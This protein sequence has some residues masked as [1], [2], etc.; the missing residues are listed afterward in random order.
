MFGLGMGELLVILLIV[1][2]VFG[3]GKLPEIGSSLGQG[4]KSFKK[5]VQGEEEEKHKTPPDKKDDK[6]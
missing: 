2:V 4:I 3:A 5:A 1:L 6:S